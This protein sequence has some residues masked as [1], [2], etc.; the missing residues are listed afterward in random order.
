MIVQ[1]P[2]LAATYAIVSVWVG[3]GLVRMFG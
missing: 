3:V 2:A 1:R